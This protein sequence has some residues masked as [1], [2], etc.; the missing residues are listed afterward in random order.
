MADSKLV[1]DIL[2][3]R[4]GSRVIKEVGEDAAEASRKLDGFNRNGARSL[5][6]IGNSARSMGLG[7]ASAIKPVV[8][9]GLAGGTLA[10]A[11]PPAA[12][13]VAAMA[14]AGVK[15]ATGMA[16]AA[17]SLAAVAGAA[18][19]VK[20][21]V[22]STGP[23]VAKAFGPIPKAFADGQ[24]KVDSLA[25]KGL[26]RLARQFVKVNFPA[27]H[28]AMKDIATAQNRVVVGV[29]KWVNSAR[30]QE[31]IRTV[32][33]ATSKAV[34]QLAPDITA[35]AISF[36]ELVRRG[37][38][39]GISRISDGLHRAAAAAKEFL[40][41]ISTQ[42]IQA[43]WTKVDG[44]IAA[45][46]RIPGA[47]SAAYEALQQ[48]M[49]WWQA[50]ADT[51][52]R[53]RDAV[54]AVA[55][56]VGV[57]TGGWMLALGGGLTLLQTH[58]TEVST[59]IQAT[60]D[61]F[62]QAT[63]ACGSLRPAIDGVKDAASDLYSWINDKLN[64]SLQRAADYM[65][66]A[67]ADAAEK[68]SAALARNSDMGAKAQGQLGALGAVLNNLVIPAFAFLGN[69]QLGFVTA[70]LTSMASAIN[71]VLLPA[72]RIATRL[73]VGYLQSLVV[74]ADVAFGWLPGIG[75]KLHSARSSFERFAADVNESLSGI[76]DRNVSV[77]ATFRAVGDVSTVVGASRASGNLK[78]QARAGGGPVSAG[79]P[80]LVGERGPEL[81]VP[82]RSGTVFSTERTR[83]ALRHGDGSALPG[84]G[85]TS[86]TVQIS[87]VVAGS[88][89]AVETLVVRALDRARAHG[90][91]P[92]AA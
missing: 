22:A 55:I 1:F 56:V 2:E 44:F 63:S 57:A 72:F 80:Y 4:K 38:S 46:G 71:A 27:I 28:S 68:A 48:G 32:T 50:N 83:A 77:T 45:V 20:R 7:V 73:I 34:K 64:P 41:G 26:P 15:L 47:L 84:R 81:V 85:A 31:T 49:A 30:G 21:T 35:L 33:E 29:G 37:G 8:A 70:Q 90:R 11:A 39:E 12:A 82:G 13:G 43:A 14:A 79:R 53:V 61:W 78:I 92:R 54:A 91:L 25:T 60:S 24:S 87:G 67:L 86:I 5:A 51:I 59:A 42:D 16:P 66:P 9:L 10:S 76:K 18:Q 40:D 89:H 69:I 88:E 17:A 62:D 58:W 23:A 74:G 19:L 65:S 3:K 52:N 75:D 36:G 6:S